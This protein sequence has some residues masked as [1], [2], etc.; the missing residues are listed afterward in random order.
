MEEPFAWLLAKALRRSALKEVESSI[1]AGR[2]DGAPE[3]VA[4]LVDVLG[5]LRGIPDLS[6]REAAR[7]RRV[8]AALEQRGLLQAPRDFSALLDRAHRGPDLY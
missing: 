3:R 6:D 4:D 7:V 5:R 2:L 1:R 8:V